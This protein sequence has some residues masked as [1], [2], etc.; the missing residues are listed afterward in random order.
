MYKCAIHSLIKSSFE[1][2]I[3]INLD[4]VLSTDQ[5]VVPQANFQM[6]LEKQACNTFFHNQIG[7][8]FPTLLK[9]ISFFFGSL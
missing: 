6:P 8:Q 9:T 7:F 3:S 1:P 4:L 2:P 5:L